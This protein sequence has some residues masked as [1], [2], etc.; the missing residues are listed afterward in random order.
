[1]PTEVRA[2]R[3]EIAQLRA[4]AAAGTDDTAAPG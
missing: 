2:L 3:A 1:V 4:A